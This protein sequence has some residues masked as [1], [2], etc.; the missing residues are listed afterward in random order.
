MRKSMAKKTWRPS[1]LEQKCLRHLDPAENWKILGREKPADSE[2][3]P[4][5]P[6]RRIF[7]I[8]LRLFSA[9]LTGIFFV[10][11]IASGTDSSDFRHDLPYG[12]VGAVV[13]A[14]LL[15]FYVT[16]LYRRSWNGRARWILRG[17]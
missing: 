15:G 6:F 13:L 5:A 7:Y 8:N 14:T 10:L 11:E 4:W 17:G 9:V 3:L 1:A 12:L 16:Y 2:I